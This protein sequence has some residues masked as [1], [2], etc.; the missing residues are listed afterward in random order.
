VP[1]WGVVSSA[2][3]PVL[4]AGGWTIAAMLQPPSFNPVANTV[5]SLILLAWFVAELVTAAKQVGLA[6]RA[7]G[8]AQT[9]W[10]LAVVLS[11]RA[12]AASGRHAQEAAGLSRA[13]DLGGF[14]KLLPPPSRP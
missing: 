4:M 1:W 13:R 5:S 8:A 14:S 12:A 11:C 3:S 9:I 6:E 10:P 7:V 2:A